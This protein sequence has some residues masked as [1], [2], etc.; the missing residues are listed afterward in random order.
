MSKS[1]NR[2]ALV[3]GPASPGPE[4]PPK[5]EI[6]LELEDEKQVLYQMPELS[7]EVKT[8]NLGEEIEGVKS[9]DR[10]VKVEVW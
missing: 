6:A 8:E 2:K 5:I 1:K 7:P 10:D 9:E 4:S 3:L